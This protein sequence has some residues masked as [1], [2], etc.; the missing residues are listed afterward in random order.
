MSGSEELVVLGTGN[1]TVKYCYN[2]CF[3]I[4]NAEQVF[5]VDTGGGNGILRQLDRAGIRLTQLHDI[6]LTHKHTDHLLGVIWL[7]RM[8]VQSR[9]SGGYSGQCRIYAHRELTGLVDTLARLLLQPDQAAALGDFILLVPVEDGQE[10]QI[11]GYPVRFF[12]IHSTKAKQFGFSLTL[13]SGEKL[14]CLGDEPYNPA[15]AADVAGS[16]WLLSEAF[17]LYGEAE[18][19]KPYEKHHS[20]VREACQLAQEMGVPHLVLWHTEE[21]HLS[22]RKALY[23]A[24]GRDFYSG[25]LYVPDDLD[26]IALDRA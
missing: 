1:A 25:D 6:F 16:S 19:F 10:W 20:T 26:V 5:L 21:T 22:Q 23:T 9:Q 18:R 14:T 3:A 4:R 15:N 24:E 8:I 2:T 11:A 12:D 17:C 7:I 13:H